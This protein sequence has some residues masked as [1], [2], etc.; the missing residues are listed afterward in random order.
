MFTK[1]IKE[2]LREKISPPLRWFG[3]E[4]IDKNMFDIEVHVRFGPSLLEIME[5][6]KEKISEKTFFLLAYHLV[7]SAPLSSNSSTKLTWP[8]LWCAHSTPR[9]S[10]SAKTTIRM[11]CS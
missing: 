1:N 11:T 10:S 6:Y 7:P 2:E 8:T 4:K 5:K 9:T 3:T